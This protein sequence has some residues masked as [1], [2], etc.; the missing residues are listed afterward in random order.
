MSN[1]LF[2]L[3]AA[4]LLSLKAWGQDSKI[5]ELEQVDIIPTDELLVY[6]NFTKRHT[7]NSAKVFGPSGKMKVATVIGFMNSEKSSIKVEGM[8]LFFNYDW[9]LDSL[10]FYVQPV[11]SREINGAP[12]A[13]YEDFAEKYLVTPKLKSRLYIDLSSKNIEVNPK[14][15]IYL[16]IKFLENVNPDIHNVFNISF[17]SG[18]IDEYTYILYSDGRKPQEMIG[19]G[20]YSAGMKYSVVY[21]L[22]SK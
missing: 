22:R 3:L 13:N 19:P 18:K 14:E 1:Y 12:E 11:V 7:E 10:G 2:L 21:K 17:V 5:I 4:S 16:G 9:A 8:E 15:R 20:K 6:S